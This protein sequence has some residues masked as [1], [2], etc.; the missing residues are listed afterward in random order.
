MEL[1]LAN[2]QQ[3]LL[4][5][6]SETAQA[7]GIYTQAH[8]AGIERKALEAQLSEYMVDIP[9]LPSAEVIRQRIADEFQRLETVLQPATVEEKRALIGNYV[10]K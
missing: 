4:A 6:D 3:H 5:L 9:H 1:V 2:L 7:L 10:K 8:D